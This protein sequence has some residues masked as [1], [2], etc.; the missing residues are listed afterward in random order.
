[1]LFRSIGG[2]ASAGIDLD[3]FITKIQGEQQVFSFGPEMVWHTGTAPSAPFPPPTS[4]PPP[5]TS[6]LPVV[7]CPA[8]CRAGVDGFYMSLKDKPTTF[9]SD[10]SLETVLALD[11]QFENTTNQPQQVNTNDVIIRVEPGL[12]DQTQD[13]PFPPNGRD[14]PVGK[15]PRSCYGYGGVA[16]HS[17]TIPAHS[18]I[19]EMPKDV[20]FG[21]NPYGPAE[22]VKPTQLI[23]LAYSTPGGSLRI[24]LDTSG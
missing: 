7:G 5:P 22:T 9:A 12:L 3:L 14:Y 1:M 18:G 24:R 4:A 23:L 8:P 13:Y 2:D 15:G 10:A 11:L 19:V 20:C 16:G 6:S 21:L 17:M